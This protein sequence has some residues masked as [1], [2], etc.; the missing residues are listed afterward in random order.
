MEA[1]ISF[2]AKNPIKHNHGNENSRQFGGYDPET[3]E[4]NCPAF[5]YP[6][7]DFGQGAQV[8][9]VDRYEPS[10]GNYL[11]VKE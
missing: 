8:S 10:K 6:L 11:Y 7:L 1:R 4:V 5:S 9:S 3:G 2:S